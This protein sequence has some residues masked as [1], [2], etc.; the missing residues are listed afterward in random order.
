M[1][2]RRVA[3]WPTYLLKQIPPQER[4]LLS[5]EA[6]AQ[7]VSVNDIIRFILCARYNLNC[8]RE[9]YRYDPD[10]DQGATNLLLRLQPK[11]AKAL[12]REAAGGE[13][14]RAI[15]LDAITT[16]YAS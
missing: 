1:S 8:P 16:H 4:R 10:R 12:D 15:I 6:A 3:S 14:K 13:S 7:N 2:R 5:A 11:L 9:S